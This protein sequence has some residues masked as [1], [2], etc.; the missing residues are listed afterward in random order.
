MWKQPEALRNRTKFVKEPQTGPD[1]S[2][3]QTNT[4]SWII[5]KLEHYFVNKGPP[6]DVS[7][8]MYVISVSAISD[9]NM[10]SHRK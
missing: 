2:Q 5:L 3:P 10:V 6:T 9:A 4:W 7:V 8:T 1:Y